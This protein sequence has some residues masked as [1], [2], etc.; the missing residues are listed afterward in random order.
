MGVP[1]PFS[2]AELSEADK[3]AL[4]EVKRQIESGVPDELV[5]WPVAPEEIDV[6]GLAEYTKSSRV[7]PKDLVEGLT[8]GASE[9]LE[10]WKELAQCT[11]SSWDNVKATGPLIV[12]PEQGEGCSIDCRDIDWS[13]VPVPVPSGRIESYQPTTIADCL[14]QADLDAIVPD[15]NEEVDFCEEC[16]KRKAWDADP[17]NSHS[18]YPGAW[19]HLCPNEM[20]KCGLLH[21]LVKK[22]VVQ[23]LSKISV[24]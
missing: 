5:D 7:T 20:Y 18:I 4:E 10:A 16:R 2:M 9:R 11:K 1:F 14:S 24:G 13:K 12:N 17:S 6:E 22:I 3:R 19:G 23:I 8:C 15:T 21:D